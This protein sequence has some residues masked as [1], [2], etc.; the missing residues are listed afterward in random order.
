[1]TSAGMTWGNTF[2]PLLALMLLAVALPFATVPRATRSQG[3]LALGI[4][5]A[6][7]TMLAVAAG[8]FGWLHAG[9][10]A[11]AAALLRPTAMSALAWGPFLA[12]A[13][14]VRAQA[15]ERRRGEDIARADKTK[16]RG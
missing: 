10:G 4:G 12:L 14:L 13:W 11:R 9:A 3:R 7:A 15:V 5:L 6:A 8:L 1:M 2:G 16:R